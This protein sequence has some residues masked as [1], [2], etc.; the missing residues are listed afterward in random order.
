[1]TVGAT[2]R[3]VDRCS[4]DDHQRPQQVPNLPYARRASPGR[5]GSDLNDAPPWER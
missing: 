1:V 3:A 2:P 4:W 5:P